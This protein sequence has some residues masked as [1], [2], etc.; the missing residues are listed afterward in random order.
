MDLNRDPHGEFTVQVMNLANLSVQ[1]LRRYPAEGNYWLAN[2]PQESCEVTSWVVGSILRDHGYG[3][4]T[5]VSGMTSPDQSPKAPHRRHVW[6]E[7]RN[8]RVIQYSLDLTAQQFPELA[9]EP[10]FTPGH[11]PIA[12]NFSLNRRHNPISRPRPWHLDRFHTPPLEFVRE[13][14]AHLADETGPRSDRGA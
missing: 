2:F 1:A 11:S 14:L 13:Q 7:L 12:H 3:D 5:I 9:T 6:L 10:L 4:W 8:G